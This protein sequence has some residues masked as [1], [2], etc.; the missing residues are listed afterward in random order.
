[1]RR[2]SPTRWPYWHHLL[3]RLQWRRWLLP[4]LC[5]LP[6][7]LSLLWL[8]AQG[9]VWLVQIMLTPVLMAMGVGIL[10]WCLARLEFRQTSRSR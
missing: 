9:L 8:S 6:Y 2:F 10:T 3:I 4:A 5:A 7:G 1:M